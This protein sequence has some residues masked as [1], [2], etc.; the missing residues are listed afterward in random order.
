MS[1]YLTSIISKIAVIEI[2]SKPVT[3]TKKQPKP[4][5]A[6]LT[7]L[8]YKQLA[9]N[10]DKLNDLHDSLKLNLFIAQN[11]SLSNFKRVFSGKEVTTP[12]VWTGNI[13]EMYYFIKL[14]HIEHKYVDDLKQKQWQVTC[15]CFIDKNGELF[16]RSNF[17]SL[18]RP[19]L[20]GDKI[21]V[22]KANELVN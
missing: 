2:E 9:I 10:S 4:Q 7:S 1:Q 15:I 22:Q 3:S 5:D 11:T 14:I 8:T 20:T 12:I 13:S 6:V 19:K 18:K 16:D 17:R 21:A